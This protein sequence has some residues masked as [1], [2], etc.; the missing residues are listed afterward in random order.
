MDD[1]AAL[2]MRR[3]SVLAVGRWRVI[4]VGA[5]ERVRRGRMRLGDGGYGDTTSGASIRG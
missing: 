4:K 3:A 5:T 1:A 2:I